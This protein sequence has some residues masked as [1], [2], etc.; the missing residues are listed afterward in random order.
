MAAACPLHLFV[1]I[2]VIIVVIDFLA[3]SL[4]DLSVEACHFWL[5]QESLGGHRTSQLVPSSLLQEINSK[6]ATKRLAGKWRRTSVRMEGADKK[7]QKMIN[8]DPA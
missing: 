6:F 5:P 3:L 1:I 2:Y 7:Y 8:L 4:R